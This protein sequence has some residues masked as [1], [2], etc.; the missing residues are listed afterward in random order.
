M[1]NSDTANGIHNKQTKELRYYK[2]ADDGGSRVVVTQSF[3][4]N[5]ETAKA[6][7][8]TA[9]ALANNDTNATQLDYG[10]T[11]DGNGL[12]FTIAFGTKGTADIAAADDW[13]ATW[14]TTKD[15]L[16]AADNYVKVKTYDTI[17]SEEGDEA[18]TKNMEWEAVDATPHLF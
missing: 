14:A 12:K 15:S 11:A 18:T 2:T 7:F 10:I 6:H 9:D 3:S 17:T 5:V 8:L 1:P 4:G 13:A 16:S